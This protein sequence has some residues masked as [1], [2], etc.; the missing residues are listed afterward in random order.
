[1]DEQ[2]DDG[3][4]APPP[5]RSLLLT[6]LGE[7]VLPR[8]RGR[9]A[10]D[11]RRRAGLARLH[12]AGRAPGAVAQ[13]PRRLAD[14]RTTGPPRADDAQRAHRRA[15]AHRRRRGS[16]RSAT[17]GVGRP[18][19]GGRAPR[20]RGAPR[21]APPAALAAG[22][23]RAGV[24]R[25]RRVA[26]ART[27][28]ARASWPPPSTTSPA[29]DATSFVAELGQHGRP[30][31]GSSPTPGTSSD[32]S[33]QYQAFIED[34]ARVRAQLARGVLSPA[35]AARARLAQVPVPGPRPAR[36]AAAR[37]VAARARPRAVR[38]PPRPLAAAR[39]ASTSSRS[40]ASGRRRPP[41]R[42]D[43]AD[44]SARA[45]RHPGHRPRGPANRPAPRGPRLRE[46]LARLPGS[47]RDR[48]TQPHDRVLPLRAR[49]VRPPAEAPHPGVHARGG[50]RGAPG[51]ARTSSRS[52]GPCSSATATAA[53]SR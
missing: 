2:L 33:E 39:R 49:P 11:A 7:Y 4:S 30:A 45:A 18:L 6:V 22:L 23:G 24:A 35:D 10:G 3:R 47:S 17:V 14:R 53:R 42:H 12:P 25:R 37:A 40:R 34:F 8:P 28:S 19:A 1:M 29:A 9:L 5:A 26:D 46:A 16:T 15:A 48:D 43:T 27:S 38:R 32:V 31:R 36:R 13:H 44:R 50:A 21:G 20:P 41:G 52:S 51:A